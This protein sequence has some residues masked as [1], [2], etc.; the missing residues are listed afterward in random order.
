M[1]PPAVDDFITLLSFPRAIVHVDC[2]AFF[3]SCESARDPGLKG[4]PLVTGQERGI[5]SCP[6]YEAKAA[7]VKRG[8]RLGDAR[9]A[10]PGVI[11]MP[12][13]YELYSIYS[14][15]IFAVIRRFTPDV[16]EY[17]ID[18]AFCD[19]TGLRRMYRSS[20]GDIA[21][22]IKEDI[23]K[24]LNL[25]VSVGLSLS[26]SLA[27]ICSK[28]NKP[29]G[30]CAVPGHKLHVF[31][32][33]VPLERVC[34]FGP[35]TVAL[36]QKY[37]IRT[38]LDYVRRPMAFA[39]KILGKVGMELWQE[40]RGIAVYPVVTDA[41]HI[42]ATIS[43]TKTFSPASRDRDLVKAQ[44]MR[45]LESAF[46]KLRRHGLACRNLTVYLRR[47]DFSS[48]GLEGRINRHSSS[49]LDFTAACGRL[50]DEVFDPRSLYRSTG[51]ILSDILEEGTDSADLFD[52]PIRVERVR[53]VSVAVD[54]VNRM[55]GKH[56]IHIAASHA[57]ADKAR[58]PR[59][60]A[61]WRKTELLPGE[62]SRQRLNIP[63]LKL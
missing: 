18:E 15:R 8:M 5:V 12:S 45:N 41:K 26:K 25:T 58:H 7:G 20:Y 21:R 43:K 11:I 13:D 16:E 49:T 17:S 33:Q 54:E 40:L 9:R 23:R 46:I 47:A 36:L 6:S 42:Y 34:G 50:F 59:N 53:K 29:D 63:L 48:C 60:C 61:S 62:T 35:N 57:V 24:E 4:K 32:A 19:I 39:Q 10:C 2:D 38:V 3:T 22:R 1:Q 56:A 44:L 14:E 27:K 55:F 31:L 51:V 37:N 52:D 28:Q 30:F